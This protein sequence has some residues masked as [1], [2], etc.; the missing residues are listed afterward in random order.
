M[1]DGIVIIENSGSVYACNRKAREVLDARDDLVGCR[2][3]DLIPGSPSNGSW[4]TRRRW[5]TPW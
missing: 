3:A 4:R 5:T 1:D 2:A